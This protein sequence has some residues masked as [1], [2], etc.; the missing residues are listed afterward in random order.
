MIMINLSN[1]RY[2]IWAARYVINYE[3]RWIMIWEM[4]EICQETPG[5]PW[6]LGTKTPYPKLANRAGFHLIKKREETKEMKRVEKMKRWELVDQ[7]IKFHTE[8]FII[9]SL[10][11]SVISYHLIK[12][13]SFTI[14]WNGNHLKQQLVVH[15]EWSQWEE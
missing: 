13:L 4:W 11:I 2:K 15:H 12:H 14:T 10:T 1:M 9:S 6:K 3:I 7:I 8:Y 5:V